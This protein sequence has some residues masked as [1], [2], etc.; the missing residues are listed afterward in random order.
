ME[1]RYLSDMAFE[2]DELERKALQRIA[3]A[4]EALR[5]LLEDQFATKMKD[6][7]VR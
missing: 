7:E 4:K 1:E 5:Q 6:R 3:A 2:R